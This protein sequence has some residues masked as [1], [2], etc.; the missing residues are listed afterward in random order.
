MD[1]GANG[2]VVEF[3]ST[4]GIVVLHKMPPDRARVKRLFRYLH[5]RNHRALYA[6]SQTGAGSTKSNPVFSFRFGRTVERVEMAADMLDWRVE[7]VSPQHWMKS[8]ALGTIGTIRC[9]NKASETVKADFRRMHARKKTEWK[10]HLKEQA[11]RAFPALA[12]HITL[13]NCDAL[14]LLHYARQVEA[15]K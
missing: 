2:A 7:L 9:P 12:K 13:A 11:K 1:P 15:G 4:T 3:C 5:D 10:N 6:E 8:L 14:L